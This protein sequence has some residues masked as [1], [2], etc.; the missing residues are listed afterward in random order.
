MPVGRPVNL[1]PPCLAT[2]S[3]FLLIGE[4]YKGIALSK[5]GDM[6]A[7]S[8]YAQH[9]YQ[10]MAVDFSHD[11]HMSANCKDDYLPNRRGA[12]NNFV[13]FLWRELTLLWLVGCV[14]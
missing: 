1:T 10:V 12:C 14:V 5:S 4:S 6:S 9:P 13:G 7:V 8:L 2:D 3:F 11:S